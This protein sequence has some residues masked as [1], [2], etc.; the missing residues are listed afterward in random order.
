MQRRTYQVGDW[1]IYRLPKASPAPGRRAQQVS[2]AAHGELYSYSVDKFWIITGV[3]EDGR[4]QARTRRGKE[5]LLEADDPRL[6]PVTWWQ[7]WYFGSRFREIERSLG[8][9]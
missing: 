4:L 5:H 3:L 2:P 8:S 7:R 6:R 9:A 1:V